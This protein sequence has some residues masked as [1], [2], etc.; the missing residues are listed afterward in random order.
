[1][2]FGLPGHPGAVAADPVVKEQSPERVPVLLPRLWGN[3]AWERAK[4]AEFVRL[5]N[6]QVGKIT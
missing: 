5:R 6:V 1:M 2:A 3:P 4:K